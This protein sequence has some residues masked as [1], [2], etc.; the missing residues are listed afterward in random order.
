MITSRDLVK[1]ALRFEEL[2]RI[3]REM[4]FDD[5]YLAK[6]YPSDVASPV[7]TY[8]SDRKTGTIN[9]KG[10]WTDEWGCVWEAAEEGVKGEV[11]ISP[12]SDWSKLDTFHPPWEVLKNA[13]FSMV[14]KSCEETDKFMIGFWETAASPFQRMQFLRGTENLLMDL[15]Y[16][17][18]EVYRL[19]DMVHDYFLKQVEM[20]SKTDVDGIHIEDD[21]GTQTALLISPKLWREFYKPL[22]KDYCDMAH[23]YG[24][25]ILMHSDGYIMD[26]IDDLIEVGVD[27]VNS[28]LFCM[29]MDEI[30]RRFAGRICFW[31]EIDRQH[32]LPFGSEEEVRAGVRRVAN[33]LMKNRKTGVVAQSFWGKDIPMANI[34]AV[35]DE[36]SKM[37]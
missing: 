14:N 11:K 36:W 23:K 18:A 30:E 1:K 5:A 34:R 16:G 29:D 3:P 20:W 27:A 32:L 8:K 25:Y 22:Y 6:Y 35:Y 12:L 26:I 15:A 21:W 31:G 2:E 9:A 10:F 33:T 24:K 13:D 4:Y 19:R 37:L 17:D 7:Y 28:Q